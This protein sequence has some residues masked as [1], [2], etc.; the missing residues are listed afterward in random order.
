MCCF[1]FFVP[2]TTPQ[3]IQIV[4]TFSILTILSSGNYVTFQVAVVDMF[5]RVDIAVETLPRVAAIKETASC[6]IKTRTYVRAVSF[7]NYFSTRVQS[8]G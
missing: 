5:S 3:D 2:A 6:K 7:L 1:V 8:I 4:S